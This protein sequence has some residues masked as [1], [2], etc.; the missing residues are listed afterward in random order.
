MPTKKTSKPTKTTHETVQN[1]IKKLEEQIQKL[2]IEIQEK[3]DK[4]LRTLAD[5]QNYQKRIEKEL[6]CQKEDI[7]KKYLLELLD[8]QELLK[9]AAEDENPKEGL[10]LLLVN[11]EKFF[12]KE[13]VTCI[14]CKGKSFDHSIHH[15]ITIIEKDDC[16]DDTI[17][18][19]VK[20]GY[21]LGGRLLR[22]SQVIVG[23]KKQLTPKEM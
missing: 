4:Y 20:K 14:E 8:F 22:P 9:K 3:N 19:E 15:A 7:K 12:E 10:K 6:T 16:I 5:Y 2:T 13:G 18:D 23:K 1:K 21:M 11:F 17:L